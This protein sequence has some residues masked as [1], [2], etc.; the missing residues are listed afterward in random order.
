MNPYEVLGVRPGASSREISEAYRILAQIYHPDRFTESPE[1][2]REEAERRMQ[3]LN[4]AFT[5][6]RPGVAGVREAEAWVRATATSRTRPA[7]QGASTAGPATAT[8]AADGSWESAAR[9]R[10]AE[11][12]RQRQAQE[13]EEQSLPRGQAVAR[14]KIAF[15]PSTLLGLGLARETNKLRCRGCN[16][17]QWLPQGWREQL[18]SYDY[19]CSLCDRMILGR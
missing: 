16:S 7:G 8:R 13:A 15:R 2:I 1:R 6:A 5:Q 14:P 18:A 3:V 11:A 17:V 19:H 10:A 9:Y 4:E 12:A